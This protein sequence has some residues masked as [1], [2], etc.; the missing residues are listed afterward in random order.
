[1]KQ[2]MPWGE[3]SLSS[4]SQLNKDNCMCM[5]KANIDIFFPSTLHVLPIKMYSSLNFNCHENLYRSNQKVWISLMICHWNITLKLTLYCCV[6]CVVGF[7]TKKHLY[8][9]RLY[10]IADVI[11]EE[12]YLFIIRITSQGLWRETCNIPANLYI[13]H[14]LSSSLMAIHQGI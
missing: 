13:F 1:M 14:Q 2:V 7:I 10:V 11:G 8:R 5:C 6:Q 3:E 9:R 4:M 12:N